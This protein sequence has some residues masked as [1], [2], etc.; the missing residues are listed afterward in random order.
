MAR[1]RSSVCQCAS[2]V[3]VVN[4]EGNASKALLLFEQ[5]CRLARGTLMSNILL[6]GHTWLALIDGR[7]PSPAQLGPAGQWVEV[8]REGR[9]VRG[10]LQNKPYWAMARRQLP[11]LLGTGVQSMEHGVCDVGEGGQVSYA[12]HLPLPV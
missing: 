8:T 1:V 3:T 12:H 10:M 4:A 11:V 7:N 5:A 9:F 2:P 6:F